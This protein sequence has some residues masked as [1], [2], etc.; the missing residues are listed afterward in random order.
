MN[1]LA[2]IG[3]TGVGKTTTARLL[4]ARLGLPCISLDDTRHELLKET[5]FDAAHASELKR[6][7][8]EAVIAYWETYNPHVIRRTLELHPR[9]V[10]DFGAIH[11]V[12]ADAQKL[13]TVQGLLAGFDDVI[14]LL[15]SSDKMKSLE[16][17]LERG[18]ELGMSPETQAMWRRIIGRFITDESNYHLCTKTVFTEGKTPVAVC[19]EI[20]RR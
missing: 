12:Y 17:L 20:V 2:L 13:R 8:F 19:D 6:R 16:I 1:R 11:S 10:F 7:D 5:D 4:A 15:P 18:R 9:G 3:P 14:L